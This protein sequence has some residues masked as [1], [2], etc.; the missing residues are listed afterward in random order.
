MDLTVCVCVCVF[1]CVC[2]SVWPILQNELTYS[3]IPTFFITNV[4]EH[5]NPVT[6]QS[7]AMD[8][9]KMDSKETE[10]CRGKFSVF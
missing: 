10:T 5:Y 1:V 6:L 2:V 3:H 9:L 4:N 8:H 7:T